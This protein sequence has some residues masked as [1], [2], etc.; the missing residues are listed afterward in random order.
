MPTDPNRFHPLFERWAR[1]VR[2][3]LA[4]R[5]ALTGAALGLLVATIPAA[6]AWKTRHGALRPL[7][8]L[9]G[10]VGAGAGLAIAR[11]KRW[12]DTDVALY[13][14][15]RL[16]TEETITTAVGMRNESELDDPTRAASRAP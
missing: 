15:D 3:R 10:V 2:G 6:I 4:L 12:S 9:V 14:D 7:A 16:E 11:R 1:R 13:L 8:A 5:H